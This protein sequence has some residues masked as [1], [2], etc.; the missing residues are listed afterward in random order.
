MVMLTVSVLNTFIH[1]GGHIS[2]HTAITTDH[3]GP[4]SSKKIREL[5]SKGQ[6]MNSNKISVSLICTVVV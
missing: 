5:E 2:L 1:V 4:P 6:L 3:W